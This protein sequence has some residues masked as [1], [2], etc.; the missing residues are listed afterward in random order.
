[1]HVVPQC[2]AA[3]SY[4]SGSR[5]LKTKRKRKGGEK[6]NCES[7]SSLI[8][9]ETMVPARSPPIIQKDI[10][11]PLVEVS[12]SATS[13]GALIIASEVI[14]PLVRANIVM[15]AIG[16]T[17]LVRVAGNTLLPLWIWQDR[18]K[19]TNAQ[20]SKDK[21]KKHGPVPFSI[22]TKPAQRRPMRSKKLKFTND[23]AEKTCVVRKVGTWSCVLSAATASSDSR[24]C[25]TAGKTDRVTMNIMKTDAA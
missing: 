22:G 9:N 6:R 2:L 20:R 14:K 15:I 13:L 8:P 17:S 16:A 21:T 12:R 3:A 11:V 7:H 5:S 18:N 19:R 24:F 25:V 4:V 1:M 10:M 23:T